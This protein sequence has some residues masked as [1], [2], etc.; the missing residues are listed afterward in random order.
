VSLPQTL[1]VATEAAGV[2]RVLR[3][4]HCVKNLLLFL[5]VLMAHEA[6]DGAR[7]LSASYG[8]IVFSLVASGLYV[9]NDML[10]VKADR[11]HPLKRHRPIASGMVRMRAG[12]LL[13]ASLV[14]GG[15][16]GAMSLLPAAFVGWLLVYASLG[17]AYSSGLKRAVIVDVIILALFY[18]IRLLAGGVAT[19]TPVSWWLVGFA[20]FFFLSLALLKRYAELRI[21]GSAADRVYTRGDR[22]FVVGFGAAAGHLAML[23]FVLYVASENATAL[24]PHL[25]FLWFVVLP[26]LYWTARMWL[27]AHQGR[28]SVDPLVF[29][30]RDPASYAAGALAA[31]LVVLAAS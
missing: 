9:L 2:V 15:F 16:L 19:G 18:V 13:A 28:M 6:A 4:H 24:Y 12:A 22:G 5:P 26:L 10:D 14:T 25:G 27:I 23:V 7:L 20:M 17:V 1:K 29:A 30:M 31:L 8:F 3:V 11:L 21:M